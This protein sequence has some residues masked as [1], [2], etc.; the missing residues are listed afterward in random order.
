MLQTCAFTCS[1][2]PEKEL[3]FRMVKVIQGEV[4]FRV[5]CHPRFDYARM[6]HTVERR[7]GAL[8]FRPAENTLPAMVLRSTIPLEVEGDGVNQAFQLKAGETAAFVFGEDSEDA[9]VP[10]H[11][12][13]R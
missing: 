10:V 4:N 8:V 7:D 6:R 5:Q 13:V 9:Q 11:S 1:T 2:S 12:T 3:S